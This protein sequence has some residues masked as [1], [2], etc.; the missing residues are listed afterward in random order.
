MIPKFLKGIKIQKD[1]QS[2]L[3]ISP[4]AILMPHVVVKSSHGGDLS[5]WGGTKIGDYSRIVS[6]NHLSIGKNC[7]ISG[8]VTIMD[9]DHASIYNPSKYDLKSVDIGDNVWIGEKSTIFASIGDRSIVGAGTV[10]TKP[11][12]PDSIAYMDHKLKIKKRNGRFE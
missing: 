1:K 2:H 12:P 6:H 7:L 3:F 5:I 4:R 11:I 10:V 8:Y 9:F